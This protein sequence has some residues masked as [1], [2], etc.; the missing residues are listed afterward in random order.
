MI[1]INIKNIGNI[2]VIDN[3]VVVYKMIRKSPIPFSKTVGEL[4]HFDKKVATIHHGFIRKKIVFQDFAFH[5]KILK[6]QIFSSIF[7]I[8]DNLIQVNHN[9]FFLFNKN[10]CKV[11]YNSELVIEITIKSTVDLSGY[12][13]DL[14]FFIENELVKQASLI[15]FIIYSIEYNLS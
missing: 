14:K 13:L 3:N 12:N 7:S 15:C 5:V 9:P 4:F 11:Y 2:T 8:D 6:Q 10:F 1:S